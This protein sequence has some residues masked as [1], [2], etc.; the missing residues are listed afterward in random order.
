MNYKIIFE[1]GVLDSFQD[2]IQYYEAI[3]SKVADK[4]HKEFFQK[5]DY[6]KT[7]PLQF[8]TRYRQIRIAN[9]KSFPIGIHF[10]VEKNIVLVIK[11]LHHKQFYK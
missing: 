4:F 11:I 7:Y 2:R 3:S 9:L 10:I 1:D 5:I 8:W 6:I